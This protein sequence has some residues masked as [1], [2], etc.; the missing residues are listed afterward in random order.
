MELVVSVVAFINDF[1]PEASLCEADED[2]WHL[3][4]GKGFPLDNQQVFL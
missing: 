2:C 3:A 4:T 1:S